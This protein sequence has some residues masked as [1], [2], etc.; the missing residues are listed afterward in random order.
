MPR[1]TFGRRLR[2][3]IFLPVAE[4]E[5]RVAARK[6]STVLTRVL[7][8]LAAL[9]ITLLFLGAFSFRTFGAS[10]SSHG[11]IVFNVLLWLTFVAT[12][13]AGL[14]L[15]ADTISEEKREGTFGLLFLTDLT[16]F[17]VVVGKLLAS[18]LVGFYALL[19]VFPVM[20]I[21]LLMGG[22]TG[23]EFW[24]SIVA[25]ASTMVLSLSCGLFVSTL[26]RG[27]HRAMMVTFGLL[28]G[29][30]IG[31]P[32]CDGLI[33][34]GNPSAKLPFF[35]LTSPAFLLS[36]SGAWALDTY[37]YALAV[38]QLL[39]VL[40]F[41]GAIVLAPTRW[42]DRAASGTARTK[43]PPTSD[44]PSPTPRSPRESD[45]RSNDPIRWLHSRQSGPR[46]A[47]L[48]WTWLMIAGTGALIIGA[49]GNDL[50]GWSLVSGLFVLPLYLLASM[51]GRYLLEGRR[52]GSLELLLTTPVSPREII[53]GQW[54]GCRRQ[55]GLAIIL[56][57]LAQTTLSVAST[58]Q[59]WLTI[60]GVNAPSPPPPTPTSSTTPQSGPPSSAG[61]SVPSNSNSTRVTSL[62]RRGVLVSR[63]GLAHPYG[64]PELA[65][66]VGIGMLSGL[67]TLLNL[68]A[69]FW[70]GLWAGLTSGKP[71]AA[72]LKT[73]AYVQVIPWLAI[74]FCTFVAGPMILF[75]LLQ[76][77]AS[78]W[79][80]QWYLGLMTGTAALLNVGKDLV[81]I[82]WARR[83]LFDELPRRAT[84]TG[85]VR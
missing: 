25:L 56:L 5:L 30:A 21:P 80:P 78:S 17:D 39:A 33:G 58:W 18:S 43:S 6:R 59:M 40:L 14:F 50:Q 9:A 11:Q 44:H 75:G 29:L 24:K 49:G 83:S 46:R 60:S 64:W 37:V 53:A 38:N 26:T 10:S 41:L 34:L 57:V 61:N 32:L 1:P 71:A 13:L 62:G 42:Q 3:V 84:L 70:F 16:G 45:D 22:V 74:T 76:S 51:S 48:G 63:G 85:L 2:G 27:S 28:A 15:T 52:S 47:A 19:A 54:R 68:A 55:F 4:R 73:L 81:Y 31:G 72:S 65:G 35:S 12:L 79:F 7:G 82:W 77:G 23:T 8:A 69:L 36:Q 20:G 66:A 67:A